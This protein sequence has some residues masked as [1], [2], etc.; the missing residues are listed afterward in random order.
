MLKTA[1]FRRTLFFIMGTLL[2]SSCGNKPAVLEIDLNQNWTFKKAQDTLWNK[3][4][5][6]GTVHSDLMDIGKIPDPYYRLNE[7]DLQ[8]ID[9]EDWEYKTLFTVSKEILAK[10]HIALDFSGL[11]TYSKIYLNDSLILQTDNMFRNYSVEV[12]PL[13]Q[14]GENR[15]HIL[16]VSPINKGIEKY[17]ALGYKIPVSDNDLAKIGKVEGEK[18]VSIFTRKAGYHFGW[19]WGPRLVTSGI[20][21]PIKLRSYDHHRIDDL[22]IQQAAIGEKANLTA[23]IELSTTEIADKTKIEILVNDSIV[24]TQDVVLEV[25][26]NNFNIPFEIE[27]P[28]L[29]WPNGMGEQI[30][31]TIE[32]R[33]IS[34]SYVDKKAHK[35]GLRTIELVREPDAIGASFYFKVNGHPVFMKGANYIPQDVFLPRAKQA[36][37]EHILSSAQ[38]ANM[39]MLRV[40]GGGIY[41]DDMF[42]QM[43]DEKG[44]LVWQ[45]FMFACAMFP[46]DPS[47]LEN[48]K[49]EAIDNVKR[50][51]NHTS[52]ALWCGNNEIL[53]AWENWGWKNQV[54][55]KQSQQ[56]ADTIWKAYDDIFHKILPEVVQEY[57]NTRAYWP[58]SPGSDFGEKESLVK[59][60]AHYW[61]VWW[62]KEPFDKY[63]TEIP[64]FMSEYGFQSFPELSTVEKYTQPED[65]DIYS[66]VMTSHQRSSIGNV[67]IEE[68]MLRDYKKPKEFENFL[69]VSQL[70]Q[71]H[72][73][74]IGIEAHR[75]NRDRCMGSLYWQINDCWPVASWSSIDYYGKWKALH[76]EAKKSFE[77]FLITFED[78]A[79]S[80]K[81]YI[82]SDSLQPVDAKLK[83]R[84]LDFEGNEINQWE[85]QVVVAPN[86]SKS[87]LTIPKRD[88][89]NRNISKNV[90]L[91]GEMI[92]DE[93]VH[94]ENM[95]Y[96]SPYKS[97]DFPNPEL[98]FSVQDNTASFK[99]TLSTRKL[100][101]N[102]FISSG[103]NANFSDNYFDMLPNTKK[104]V[105]IEKSEN[106]DLDSFKSNLKVITLVDTFTPDL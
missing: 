17:D 34:D 41:E 18:Q 76:Y 98:S 26:K 24:K 2:L 78:K 60:D 59:G 44:L 27:N 28:Q 42:Y 63:T 19:D 47:F 3:A 10:E 43:C 88:L 69:Y 15:L 75:R 30:L 45:D 62:G 4:T 33:V 39:N 64:R 100:A 66:E 36:E 68:Y 16:F 87:Y 22:F 95:R 12:K 91:Q 8:W 46:G 90:L 82:V 25:G 58:S 37:Y 52:I 1:K 102:V 84:L 80:L 40:W 93:K 56:I 54:A 23:Q 61:M 51:R 89:I 5:V 81:V 77:N 7:H 96:L 35:I 9:K 94:T 83:L 55:Q 74:K 104:T 85:E 20:W 53:S 32:A 72:G 49:Q 6:P 92:V 86:Q 73:I 38:E 57:D 106:E 103:S 29:W 50:L 101:K 67:T 13:L 21:R 31:Y 14:L 48:V 11:D 97:L 99:V 105:T 65:H 70:L 71:A 79:D